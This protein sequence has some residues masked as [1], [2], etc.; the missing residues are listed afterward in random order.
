MAEEAKQELKEEK[1]GLSPV[2]IKRL[3]TAQLEVLRHQKGAHSKISM[4][5]FLDSLS[6][7]LEKKKEEEAQQEEQVSAMPK[8]LRYKIYFGMKED[9]DVDGNPVKVPN[10]RSPLFYGDEDNN[11]YFNVESK[12]WLPEKPPILQ[13]LNVRD[14]DDGEENRDV[15]DAIINGVMDDE[16]FDSLS[17][18]EGMLDNRSKSLYGLIQRLHKEY[19]AYNELSKSNDIEEDQINQDS[20]PVDGQVVENKGNNV[21]EQIIQTA[22]GNLNGLMESRPVFDPKEA[23]ENLIPQM[24]S[25]A[26][27]HGVERRIRDLIREELEKLVAEEEAPTEDELI[28]QETLE[29]PESLEPKEEEKDFNTLEENS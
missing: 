12:E 23:G 9:K 27:G 22:T 3:V 10:P 21:A 2:D 28:H 4:E 16:D 1:D 7:P 29:N 8:L 24:I 17:K 18:V 26:F 25:A 5:E 19:D 20:I 11:R 13:H 14:M 15:L 6:A